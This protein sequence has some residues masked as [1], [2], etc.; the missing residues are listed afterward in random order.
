MN[1]EYNV[2][3]YYPNHIEG[4]DLFFYCPLYRENCPGNPQFVLN[5]KGQEIKDCR[6]CDFPHDSENHGKILEILGSQNMILEVPL[7]KMY[8][9][10]ELFLEVKSGFSNMDK[11]TLE[12]HQAIAMYLYER[13][14]A[15]GMIQIL[16][17]PFSGRCLGKEGFLFGEKRR[18]TCSFL[19]KLGLSEEE[20]V[21]GYFYAFHVP[22]IPAEAGEKLSLLEQCYLENWLI[23]FL[24][25]GRE[26]ARDYLFRKHNIEKPHYVTDS[27]GPGYYGMPIES[28]REIFKVFDASPVGVTL[29]EHGN[30]HPLKSSVGMYLVLTRDV[31]HLMEHDCVSCAGNKSGCN[32]CRSV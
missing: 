16:L 28:I 13:F 20:V 14:L 3:P 25:A 27:F 19:E 2:Y 22:E 29:L 1:T 18:I 6:G 11:E 7:E 30:M 5:E 9:K 32:A 26:Y 4:S 8:H 31:S 24:D 12:E 15:D 10:A 23:S 21:S 17:Q